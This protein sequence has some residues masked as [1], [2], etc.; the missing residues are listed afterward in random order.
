[1]VFTTTTDTSTPTQRLRRASF[2]LIYE[3]KDVTADLLP[4]VLSVSYTD[5]LS[6]ESSDL[7]I[8][9]IN[10]D[11]RWMNDWIPTKGDRLRC[12]FKYEGIEE[13]LDCGQFEIDDF[14]FSGSPDLLRLSAIATIVTGKLREKR[15]QSYEKTT[16][17]R[18]A[19]DVARRNGLKLTGQIKNVAIYRITQNEQSDLEFVTK[20]ADEYGHLTKVE[21]GQ[22]IFYTN[23]DLEKVAAILTLSDAQIRRYRLTSQSQGTYSAAEIKYQNPGQKKLITHKETDPSIKKGDTLKV[24]GRA[25]SKAQAIEKCRSA[26]KKANDTETKMDVT[27]EG[28]RRLVAGVNV[29]VTGYGRFD[30]KYQVEE[31]RHQLSKRSGWTT[32]LTLR[33][34][35]RLPT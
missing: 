18:V 32:D 2:S 24:K 28:D 16:L 12:K 13:V 4:I 10:D 11:R 27:V 7:D 29:Q 9:L 33:K 19:S 6:G 15:T 20:L 26:L 30:D 34:I 35:G 1:M 25:E 23:E 14:E 8:D 22:L 17:Q 31:A 3:G 5:K 21:N